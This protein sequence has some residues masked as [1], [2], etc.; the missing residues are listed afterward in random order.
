MEINLSLFIRVAVM[1]I[2]FMVP[3]T[4]ILS[5]HTRMERAKEEEK[6]KKLL[7]KKNIDNEDIE[8]FFLKFKK[9]KNGIRF[10]TI[11]MYTN[12]SLLLCSIVLAMVLE[13]FFDIFICSRIIQWA[14]I[15]EFLLLGTWILF[16]WHFKVST[17]LVEIKE[18]RLNI[19]TNNKHEEVL[20]KKQEKKKV[21][22]KIINITR[23]Y[24]KWKKKKRK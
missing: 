3:F 18:K 12:A 11:I 14:I 4:V 13:I 21:L 15:I 17:T 20:K 23:R 19:E 10:I 16:G 9:V 1:I 24:L 5:F 6:I 22:K 7:L 8:Y 2:A